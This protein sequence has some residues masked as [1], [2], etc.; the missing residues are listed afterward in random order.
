MRTTTIPLKLSSVWDKNAPF[1]APSYRPER[2]AYRDRA[3]DD[4]ERIASEPTLEDGLALLARP[5][6]PVVTLPG[7]LG[8]L[9][10]VR[11]PTMHL[12]ELDA[13]CEEAV[14]MS[15]DKA[16]EDLLAGYKPPERASPG[17]PRRNAY[18]AAEVAVMRDVQGRPLRDTTLPPLLDRHDRPVHVDKDGNP[19]KRPVFGVWPYLGSRGQ[20]GELLDLEQITHTRDSL[21]SRGVTRWRD[22]GRKV[23][24]ALGAWPWAVPGGEGKLSRNW[25]R[26]PRYATALAAWQQGEA[27]SAG[28]PET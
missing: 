4:D 18:L 20:H 7:G 2:V 12:S 11:R 21:R 23:M 3:G 15:R 16:E 25:W 9:P 27:P 13:A 8:P 6:L 28:G 19:E 22:D 1:P 24:A 17:R 10:R 14:M 5:E 26:E